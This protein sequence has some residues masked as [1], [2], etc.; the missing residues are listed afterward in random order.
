MILILTPFEQDSYIPR[1]TWLRDA[2]TIPAGPE[3]LPRGIEEAF[4]PF[5]LEAPFFLEDA[6]YQVCLR[7]RC[8][9]GFQE[10]GQR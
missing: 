9:V 6:E 1:R 3:N 5:Y 8:V 10:V 4:A 2:R 7:N